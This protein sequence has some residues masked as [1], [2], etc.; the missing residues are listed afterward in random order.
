MAV[1]IIN[2]KPQKEEPKIES[3]PEYQ[4]QLVVRK[5]GP[6]TRY[7][8]MMY[9]PGMTNIQTPWSANQVRPEIEDTIKG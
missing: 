3:F 9:R 8:W 4:F 1:Y 7:S 5:D 6:S 2:G